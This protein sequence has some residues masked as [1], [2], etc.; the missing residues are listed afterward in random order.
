[1]LDVVCKPR[2]PAF[3]QGMHLDG[4]MRTEER[5]NRV[6]VGNIVRPRA[7]LHSPGGSGG[8]G[9]RDARAREHLL[10]G[11]LLL[12][13]ERSPRDTNAFKVLVLKFALEAGRLSPFAKQRYQAA[14][15]SRH[16]LAT[17]HPS[18]QLNHLVVGEV[19]VARSLLE[20]VR[21]AGVA[22][23]DVQCV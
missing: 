20:L 13:C 5:G 11:V 6:V 7:M 19:V 14:V 4:S 2:K 15:I 21:K 10:Q 3:T 23:H 1:M 18:A 8:G 22:H 9:K 16:H 12:R 17:Q